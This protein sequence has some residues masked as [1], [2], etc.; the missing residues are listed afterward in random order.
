MLWL[1]VLESLEMSPLC[2]YKKGN[3]AI[4]CA[5]ARFGNY[6]LVS[7]WNC[8]A[9]SC[10]NFSAIARQRWKFWFKLLIP[11][12]DSVVSLAIRWINE[13]GF[14]WGPLVISWTSCYNALK[15]S[16]ASSFCPSLFP[17]YF[18]H[19]QPMVSM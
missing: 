16:L 5:A 19:S 13:D 7:L 10:L 17:R 9:V 11:I 1:T 12:L 18:M 4:L 6:E 2:S 3:F 15:W 8:I 14:S